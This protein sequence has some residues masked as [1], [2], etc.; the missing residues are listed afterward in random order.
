[1]II[2]LRLP[3]QSCRYNK[4]TIAV[5]LEKRWPLKSGSFFNYLLMESKMLETV[6]ENIRTILRSSKIKIGIVCRPG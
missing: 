5:Q 2:N 3:V 4:L 1:M 6:I